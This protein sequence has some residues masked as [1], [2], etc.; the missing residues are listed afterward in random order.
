MLAQ[1]HYVTSN[2]AIPQLAATVQTISVWQFWQLCIPAM[3][4]AKGG[5]GKGT[6]TVYG[7]VFEQYGSESASQFQR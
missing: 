3:F 1:I 4:G 6:N 7:M 5:S 2:Q